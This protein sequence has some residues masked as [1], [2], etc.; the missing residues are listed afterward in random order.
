ME[1]DS[2]CN[3]DS[4]ILCAMAKLEIAKAFC[5][6]PEDLPKGMNDNKRTRKEY[7]KELEIL[8]NLAKSDKNISVAYE[9]LNKIVA[10]K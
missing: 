7:I 8:Y 10:M 1:N 4:D 9:I 2:K 5:T 3:K 6:K